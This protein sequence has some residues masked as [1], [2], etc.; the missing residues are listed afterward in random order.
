MPPIVDENDEIEIMT[1]LQ[2]PCTFSAGGP[3]EVLFTEYIVGNNP[4]QWIPKYRESKND[5]L[6]GLLKRTKFKVV[7]KRDVRAGSN[8]L[9]GIFILSL[10]NVWDE[11]HEARFVVQGY[12][13]PD[14][15]MLVFASVMLKQQTIRTVAAVATVIKARLWT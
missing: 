7:N 1:R 12:A 8:I 6:D 2:S 3:P 4:R 15:N 10:K 9:G 13:D 5:E 14:E 11:M